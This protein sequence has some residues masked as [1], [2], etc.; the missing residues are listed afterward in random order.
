M[1][2]KIITL[3][4]IASIVMTGCKHYEVVYS[5][6]ATDLPGTV[7][8]MKTAGYWIEKLDNPDEPVLTT[9]EIEI[10]NQNVLEEFDSVRTATDFTSDVSGDSVIKDIME[11]FNYSKERKFYLAD[12]KRVDKAFYEKIEK[13]IN[14]ETVPEMIT[15]TFGITLRY[16]HQRTLPTS[17]MLTYSPRDL[18]FDSLQMS[19]LDAAT[20]LTILHESSDGKWLF[21]WGP[22]SNGWLK[23]EE[24]AICS[25]DSLK[26][27]VKSEQFVV[28]TVSKGEVFHDSE[29]TD[30]NEYLRMGATLPLLEESG[31]ETLKV[32]FP[33][34]DSEGNLVESECYISREQVNIGYLPYTARNTI[35]Q[36][37]KQLNSPYGWGGMFGEQDC[38][39]F[40]CQIFATVGIKLPRNSSWQAN[41]GR[42]V[43][44]FD[45]ENTIDEKVAMLS[46]E[47]VPGVSMF[48]IPGH[49]MLY[50]GSQ[51]GNPYVIHS[52]WGYSEKIGLKDV[53]RVINRTVVSN[54]KLGE[55][56]KKGSHL[57]RMDKVIN[58]I[59]PVIGK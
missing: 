50:I 8:E 35:T 7:R 41:S 23:R 38:S 15:P 47:A 34:V 57:S 59:P 54:L 16:T 29:L 33:S 48:K 1:K 24:L 45:K 51:D 31:A 4:I 32:A 39:R 43:L 40:M 13:L 53:E 30:Y 5:S 56:T 37:F 21:V 20:P 3:F 9:E 2:N 42:L 49:I 6:A 11:N 17:E 14:V 55:G 58:V 44:E 10:F 26:K 46:K 22:R 52:T 27:Y 28:V 25:L 18:F 19:A 12:G 36:A